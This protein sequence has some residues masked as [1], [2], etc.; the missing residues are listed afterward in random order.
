MGRRLLPLTVAFL[1]A[2]LLAVVGFL[3]VRVYDGQADQAAAPS[4]GGPFA[5][6]DGDG[7]TVTDADFRGR[8]MLVYFG[9]THCPD[10]CP[11]ALND[12]AVALGKLPRTAGAQ[13]TPVFIT[14]DPER[15]TPAT[16]KDYVAAFGPSFVGLT[17]TVPAVASVEK[18]YKVYAA[19][20]PTGNGDYE[21]DH[22]SYIYVMDPA[23]RFVTTFTHETSPDDMAKDLGKL[24]S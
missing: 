2:S 23:G 22:S 18:A 14:V 21:M 1:V 13:V 15:D 16:M 9:Y 19:R 3:G 24:V 10:A 20:H 4:V 17:G 6:E 5:L 12:I 11:T 8:W 7:R